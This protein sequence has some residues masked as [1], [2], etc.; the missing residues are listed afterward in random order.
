[1]YGLTLKHLVKLRNANCLSNKKNK[2]KRIPITD[3]CISSVYGFVE[4]DEKS[5]DDYFNVRIDGDGDDSNRE[6]EFLQDSDF[7]LCRHI[8]PYKWIGSYLLTYTVKFIYLKTLRGER[9]SRFLKR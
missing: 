4:N 8:G 3:Q 6:N 1:M 5:S 7:S 2:L 9:N